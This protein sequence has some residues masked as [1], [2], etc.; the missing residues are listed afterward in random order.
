MICTYKYAYKEYSDIAYIS[1]MYTNMYTKS[2]LVLH[3]YDMFYRYV[4]KEYTGVAY[5]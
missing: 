2:T 5:I 4:Y 3:I 1:H